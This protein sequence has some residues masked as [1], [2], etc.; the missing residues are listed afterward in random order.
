MSDDPNDVADEIFATDRD[1]DDDSVSSTEDQQPEQA[2][3]AEQQQDP[4]PQGEEQPE[5]QAS[6]SEDKQRDPDTGRFVPVRELQSERQK[7]Q[8]ETRLR[9]AAEERANFYEK[10]AQQFMQTAQQPVQQQPQQPQQVELPD[11]YEDPEGY[12]RAVVQQAVGNVQSQMVDMMV[13]ASEVR[14]R[15]AHGHEAVDKALHAAHQAGIAQQFIGQPEPFEALMQ[16]HK[17]AEALQQYGDDPAA[18]R[19]NLEKEI[20]EKVLEELKSGGQVIDQQPSGNGQQQPQ[21]FPGSLVDA[22]SQGTQGRQMS[23][24]ALAD[25]MFASDRNRAV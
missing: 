24:Q 3:Q 10:Q 20:R 25:E 11:V 22:T 1:R 23:Q 8:E 16:W 21:R 15:G 12:T 6:E 7:R 13:N 19:E 18:Y 5:Q 14:A 2:V 9:E 17:R 4:E